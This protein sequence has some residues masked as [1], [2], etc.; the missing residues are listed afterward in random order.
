MGI[1]ASLAGGCTMTN[2]LV[3]TA[4]FSAQ[5]WIATAMILIGVWLSTFIFKTTQCRI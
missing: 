2:S 5:G 3:A 4:Y 1:G